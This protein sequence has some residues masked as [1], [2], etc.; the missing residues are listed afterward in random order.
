M[1]ILHL[2]LKR[3]WFDLI[4]SGAKTEEYRECKT[5]WVKRL[6]G[7]VYDEVHFRNGY[8]PD[9][10]FMRVECL[11]ISCIAY[12]YIIKLGKVLEVK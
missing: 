9:S 8:R 4:A 10:P 12:H 2:T 5:Y 6:R 11:G 1:N 3:K 7:R